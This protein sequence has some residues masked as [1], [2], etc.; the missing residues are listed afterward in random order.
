MN[1]LPARLAKDRA[2]VDGNEIR[3]DAPIRGIAEN[4]EV[5]IGV[6]PDHV[7]LAHSGEGPRVRIERIDDLGRTRLARVRLGENL[8]I[9]KVPPDLSIPAGEAGLR[10]EPGRV[11]VYVGEPRVAGV[12]A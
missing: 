9:A 2:D 10:F 4:A 8:L 12:A 1:L 3:L 11:H 5:Q 6:R 7:R